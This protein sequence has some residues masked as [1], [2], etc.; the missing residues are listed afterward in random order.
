MVARRQRTACSQM[1]P[2]HRSCIWTGTR[3]RCSLPAPHPDSA[4]FQGGQEGRKREK[5][6]GTGGWKKR[7]E[8]GKDAYELS[9]RGQKESMPG[10]L[11]MFH[12]RSMHVPISRMLPLVF[13]FSA[14]SL[15][16]SLRHR[17]KPRWARCSSPRPAR[18]CRWEDGEGK[19]KER[20]RNRNSIPTSRRPRREERA[21]GLRV[22]GRGRLPFGLHKPCITLTSCTSPPSFPSL[23]LPFLLPLCLPLSFPL[24][25]LRH[26]GGLCLRE[27]W[28]HQGGRGL[29]SLTKSLHL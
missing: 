14:H 13:C 18:R 11:F 8:A 10:L 4:L 2:G 26:P 3:T 29:P 17:C 25:L 23:T 28:Q 16:R 15:A 22:C 6:G 9:P 5:V 21:P 7:R 27:R 1:S 24:F 12:G 20:G 19:E